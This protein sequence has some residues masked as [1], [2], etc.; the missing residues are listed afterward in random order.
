MGVRDVSNLGEGHFAQFMQFNL[1]EGFL[2]KGKDL[3]YQKMV[4]TRV[5][6]F[7]FQCDSAIVRLTGMWVRDVELNIMEKMEAGVIPIDS[8]PPIARDSDSAIMM[9]T[10]YVCGDKERK[11]KRASDSSKTT[12]RFGNFGLQF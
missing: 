3:G 9:A 1:L 7:I 8:Y 2:P 6:H 4:G 10:N 11:S 12:Q 5:R